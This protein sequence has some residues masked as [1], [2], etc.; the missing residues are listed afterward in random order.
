MGD[1]IAGDRG[2]DR[3][4]ISAKKETLTDLF[5]TLLHQLDDGAGSGA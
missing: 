5:H 4:L 2:E 1:S 3:K